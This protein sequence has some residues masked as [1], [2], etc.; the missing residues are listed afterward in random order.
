MIPVRML[1]WDFRSS[2][3]EASSGCGTPAAAC[4]RTLNRDGSRSFHC[5][6]RP[7]LY[8]LPSISC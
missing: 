6:A 8:R 1:L 3:R 5:S 4:G 7:N 2:I